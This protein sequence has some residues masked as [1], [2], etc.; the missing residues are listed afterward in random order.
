MRME[1]ETIDTFPFLMTILIAYRRLMVLLLVSNVEHSRTKD[2][3]RGLNKHK[4]W[5]ST[6][7]KNVSSHSGER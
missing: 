1:N 6:F 7:Q 3:S 4:C 5:I 2:R